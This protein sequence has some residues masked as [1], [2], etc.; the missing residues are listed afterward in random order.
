MSLRGS[1]ELVISF[2]TILHAY[3]KRDLVRQVYDVPKAPKTFTYVGIT[4]YGDRDL[5]RDCLK[6]WA[7][8]MRRAALEEN[9]IAYVRQDHRDNDIPDTVENQLAYLREADF[10]SVELIWRHGKFAAFSAEK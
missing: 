2:F 9:R 7:D 1:L 4:K 5:E 10:S 6:V 3:N 8:F